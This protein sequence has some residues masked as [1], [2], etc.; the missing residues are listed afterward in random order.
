MSGPSLQLT[1]IKEA[2]AALSKLIEQA[3]M[4]TPRGV[5]EVLQVVK[6]Q[7][8]MNIG[9]RPGPLS[10]SGRLR[11]TFAIDPPRSVGPGVWEGAC[12][13]TAIYARALELGHPRWK[14]DVKYPYFGPAVKYAVSVD[15]PAILR[16]AWAGALVL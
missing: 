9:A 15:M 8:Q 3:G 2:Q 14:P 7:A 16:R 6:R 5:T 13:P 4:A 1:G 10:R 12:G 11:G